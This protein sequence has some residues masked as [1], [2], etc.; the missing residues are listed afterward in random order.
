VYIA[1]TPGI[2]GKSTDVSVTVSPFCST[3]NAGA[4]VPRNPAVAQIATVSGGYHKSSRPTSASCGGCSFLWAHHEIWKRQIYHFVTAELQPLIIDGGANVGLSVVYFKWLFPNSR[5]IAFDADPRVFQTLSENVKSFGLSD[6]TLYNNAVLTEK[7]G[8]V[9]FRPDG[10]D[11]GRVD[12][13]AGD[14]QSN[15]ESVSLRPMLQERVAMLKL[16]IEGAES[17]V[18]PEI[19]GLLKNVER[20]FVEW[21]SVPG[22]PQTLD[23][24][25]R[26]LAAA[27]FRIYLEA[28]SGDGNPFSERITVG[29]YDCM[30][31]IFAYR[32]AIPDGAFKLELANKSLRT[33]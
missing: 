11:G 27:D 2:R 9:C 16:D 5:L 28:P 23:E 4:G 24:I 13:T 31:N 25:L 22:E 8:P 29:S 19:A 15:V 32:T 20:L 17:L 18:I 26:I 33:G 7:I 30:V 21:H 1:I 10:A 6:V 3:C 12:L 14:G